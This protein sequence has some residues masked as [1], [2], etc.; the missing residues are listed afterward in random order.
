[1]KKLFIATALVL[2]MAFAG[3]AQ[4]KGDIEGGIN[5]GLNSSIVGGD[6]YWYDSGT[7]LNLGVSADYFLYYPRSVKAKMVYDEK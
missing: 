7:G 6:Y 4:K 1:M 2:G 5:V 3:H